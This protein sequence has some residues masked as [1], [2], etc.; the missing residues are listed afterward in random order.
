[1]SWVILGRW[2]MD[3]GWLLFLFVLF[4]HFWRDRQV[5]VDARTWLTVK[6]Y[7]T[8]CK[9]TKVGHSIWP[10]IEYS[11]HVSEKD[12][13]GYDLFL[14]TKHHNLNSN[15]SRQIAYKAAV[16]FKE[17]TEIDIYYNPNNLEQSALDVS[18]PIKLNVI[19]TL[20]GMLMALHLALIVWR[21]LG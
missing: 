13:M 16:A 1:M 8:A 12:F 14:D 11:Y 2:L 4:I 15:Y 17:G 21:Y 5:L 6:G 20:I 10:K 7:I 19:L 18:I 9:W 3:L